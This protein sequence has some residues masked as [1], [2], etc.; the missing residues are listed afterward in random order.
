MGWLSEGVSM[1]RY[2]TRRCHATVINSEGP[3]DAPTAFCK[4]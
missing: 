3:I 1:L 2:S 4:V